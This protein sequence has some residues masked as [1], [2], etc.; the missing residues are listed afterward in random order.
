MCT[1]LPRVLFVPLALSPPWALQECRAYGT[2]ASTANQSDKRKQRHH[3]TNPTAS[4]N[5]NTAQPIRQQAQTTTPTN[6]SDSK[7]KQRLR[8][9]N[10]TASANND[11]QQT[12]NKRKQ[13][14]QTIIRMINRKL[15]QFSK[16]PERAALLQ[17]PGRKPWVSHSYTFIE[18][19]KGGTF[20]TNA[21]PQTKCSHRKC[22]SYG[23][24]IF[25]VRVYPGFCSCLWHSRH[26]GL[27]RSVV[28]TALTP[29]PP[30]QS[31]NKHKQQYQPIN[32]TTNASNNTAQ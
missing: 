13:P 4:A 5:K 3:P 20:P 2:H 29:A 30:N 18:P 8:T 19:C 32:P 27:C 10:S 21:K 24:L 6:Q 22:R 11:T 1:Y 28:P 17:S 23:A 16:S 12:N 31:D 14:H 25:C 9:I 26:P 7:R 15:D